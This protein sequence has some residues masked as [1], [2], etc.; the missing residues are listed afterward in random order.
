MLILGPKV[1]FT[2]GKA[3]DLPC[4]STPVIVRLDRWGRVYLPKEVREKYHA[5]EFYI[6]DLPFGIVLVP[7]VEDP[8]RAL[9]EEGKKLP[10][11]PIAGLKRAIREEAEREAGSTQA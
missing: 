11:L 8:I 10:G 5:E 2:A 6:V 3:F 1:R 7:R 4:N 9:E